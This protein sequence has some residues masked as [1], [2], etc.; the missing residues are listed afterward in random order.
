MSNDPDRQGQQLPPPPPWNTSQSDY[1]SSPQ[2][3]PS[4]SQSPYQYPPAAGGMTAIPQQHPQQDPYRLPHPHPHA[5][6]YQ[7]PPDMYGAPPPGPPPV[8]YQAAAPRQRTAIACRYCRR[9]KIRCSGFDTSQDGRCSNCVRFN[10][11]CMFTPVSSQAQAFVPAHTAYPHLRATQGGRGRPGE[12]VVLYGPHGQ[13]LPHQPI[14]HG[15]PEQ[16]LP[17]PPGMYPPPYGRPDDR[18]GLPPHMAHPP[19]IIQIRHPTSSSN[20]LSYSSSQRAPSPRRNS[21]GGPEYGEPP[22][23]P[24]VSVATAGPSYAVHPAP[25]PGP[26]YGTNQQDRRLSSHSSYSYDP[27]QGTPPRAGAHTPTTNA[28]LPTLQPL[29]NAPS[30][31]PAREG[32]PTPPPGQPAI[33]GRSGLSVRDMLGPPEGQRT[34]TT[35]DSDMLNALNRGGLNK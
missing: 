30:I 32:G 16:T 34:R 6:P 27:S 4:N 12:G 26:Y 21:A 2:Y 19:P 24:P 23:L 31:P 35:T 8:V 7:R 18:T 10:Q 3:P 28:H 29:H 25:A 15:A 14:T 9:R 33:P 17:L 11:E 5:A 13:P 22:T 1:P 20:L